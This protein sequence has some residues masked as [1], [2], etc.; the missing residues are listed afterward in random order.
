MNQFISKFIIFIFGNSPHICTL[1]MS[2]LPIIEVRGTIPFS[3][4]YE[5]WAN[6]L[7]EIETITFCF[8]GS[9]VATALLLY[10]TPKLLNFLKLHTKFYNILENKL[11]NANIQSTRLNKLSKT[12]KY[13]YLG[14]FTFIPLPL[15][16]YYTS[17][18]IATI[19]NMK[20]IPALISISLGN[21]GCSLL[22]TFLSDLLNN[23]MLII[24]YL[25]LI[26]LII[27][28]IYILIKLIKNRKNT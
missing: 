6:P 3:L 7:S 22:I 26:V 14:I 25:F 8:L 16:G 5:I 12:Q 1:I 28:I 2:M 15:T 19:S 27:Y 13:I 11:K 21:L 10:F 24:F 17:S 20:F 4:S 9:I 23:Y 18:L